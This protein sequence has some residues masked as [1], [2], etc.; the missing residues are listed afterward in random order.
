MQPPRTCG[1][2][3]R[4]VLGLAVVAFGPLAVAPA[5]CAE[6]PR[7]ANLQGLEA[8]L[9]R[10]VNALRARQGLI[11][12]RRDPALDEIARAHSTDMSARRYLAHETPEGA[13]PVHRLQRAGVEGFALAGENVGLTSRSQPNREIL[14]GWLLSR[15]HRV[16]L[17]APAFNATGI[18]IA[19]ASNGTLYY[20]Q[21][22]VTFPP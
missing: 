21:L 3:L 10:A 17:L 5:T 20:T 6:A 13:N 8:E 15:E 1:R 19:R 12:L 7:D 16:N 22:Y 9:H 4:L 14:D 11:P 2:R 18:G